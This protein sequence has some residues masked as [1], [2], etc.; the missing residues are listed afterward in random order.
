MAKQ[1]R[2]K[3]G[4]MVHMIGIG[5]VGMS[6]VARLLLYKGVR[7]T[8][9]DTRESRITRELAGEGADVVIGHDPS[10]VL[11]MDLVIYSTAVAADHPEMVAAMRSGVEVAHRAEVLAGLLEDYPLGIGVTGTH[12]K[13]T[14]SSLIAFMLDKAGKDPAF[15]IGAY[16]NDYGTN[17]RG[18]KGSV[19]VAELDESDGSLLNARPNFALVNNVEADHLNYYRDFDHVVHT[20]ADFLGKNDKL[21]TA[22]VCADDPG[23]MRA[24]RLSKRDFVT[25]GLTR[26][27]D[28]FGDLVSLGPNGSRFRLFAQ[29]KDMGLF[30]L[31]LP[32][33]YN[34]SNA[35]G[36]LAVCLG[37]DIR[38][39]E[40]RDALSGFSGIENR[41]GIEKAAGVLLVKDYISH[42]T[43]IRRVLETA[44]GFNPRT[45]I[46]VFKPYRY[47]ML[48]YLKDEYAT[49]FKDADHVIITRMWDAGEKP[50]PG[51]DT[52]FLVRKVREF[53]P[54][55]DYVEDLDDVPGLL[56]KIVQPGDMI[57]FLGGPDMFEQADRLK[58]Y[59]LDQ[60]EKQGDT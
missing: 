1:V 51:I 37:L 54:K 32:G 56:M 29:G 26:D 23:A 3:P 16:L 41:F 19:L 31:P 17:A 2:V 28:F 18:S 36:A 58:Q 52:E 7:V 24:A 25:F 46:A 34:C 9:C 5:G 42:P 44:R 53:H 57:T 43:G 35:V 39:A 27:A 48:N 30:D 47:T 10:H 33:R 15:A 13:G 38:P 11:D 49:A 14:V 20:I 21:R 60:A 40:L 50:I 22:F 59:L 55:V 8:G 45:L 12:G 4:Q 6:A